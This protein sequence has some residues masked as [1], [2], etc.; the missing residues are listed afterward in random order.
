MHPQGP[1]LHACCCTFWH[2]LHSRGKPGNPSFQVLVGGWPCQGISCAGLC[3]GLADARSGLFFALARLL[4]VYNPPYFFFEN[5]GSIAGDTETWRTV[6][7]TLTIDLP[8]RVDWIILP[9]P[10]L[11]LLKRGKQAAT[12]YSEVAG[13]VCK[14][15][16]GFGG[17]RP[18]LQGQQFPSGSVFPSVSVLLR[19]LLLFTAL[20]SVRLFPSYCFR[21]VSVFPSCS[22][23]LFPSGFRLSV[24]FR[25][26]VSVWF[27]SD[28][29]L[30]C[31]TAS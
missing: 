8:Y 29:R 17:C 15:Q 25:L 1:L 12:H 22:V 24:V 18:A 5:V 26:A 10:N 28:S 20:W 9:V 11:A 30:R 31:R 23:L 13:Q 3:Q 6:M 7:K 4:L 14:S 27:P 21:L 19:L 2:R 16:S